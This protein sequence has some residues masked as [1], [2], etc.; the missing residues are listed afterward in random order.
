[1]RGVTAKHSFT[2]R[3]ILAAKL[4]PGVFAEVAT[5]KRAGVEAAAVILAGAVASAVGSGRLGDPSFFAFTIASAVVVWIAFAGA[6]F[7]LA[8]HVFATGEPR[9]PFNGTA[10]TLGFATVPQLA[11]VV[12]FVPIAG[13]ILSFVVIV[14]LLAAWTIATKSITGFS[15][16]RALG[17]VLAAAVGTVVGLS[18]V[19]RVL[20]GLT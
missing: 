8:R 12:A 10:R 7:L 14:W 15:A 13:V 6:V 3:V 16:S 5:D 19:V 9:A 4:D 11:L 1:M 17:T 2:E 20:I 18:L